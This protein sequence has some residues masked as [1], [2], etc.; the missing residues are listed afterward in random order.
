MYKRKKSHTGRREVL[1]VLHR[2]TLVKDNA[3]FAQKYYYYYHSKVTM[4][5]KMHFALFYF[6]DLTRQFC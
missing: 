4:K 1:E 6:V 5:S 2:L 3:M